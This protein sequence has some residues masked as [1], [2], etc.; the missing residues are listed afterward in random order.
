MKTKGDSSETKTGEEPVA[1]IRFV[2][3]VVIM[4]HDSEDRK[5]VPMYSGLL[6]YF[7][8]ALI[9]VARRSQ[10]GNDQ[11]HPGTPIH[12]DKNKSSDSADA[13]LRHL[14]EGEL[15]ALA[16][17]ALETLERAILNGYRPASF[18]DQ[19]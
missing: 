16:W 14:V 2:E 12:W 15:D 10:E 6:R 17:R 5:R 4:P 9:A 3:D 11:H 8:N 18:Q 1:T 19:E 7:P 13:L